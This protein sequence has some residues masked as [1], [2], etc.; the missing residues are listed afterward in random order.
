MSTG[1]KCCWILLLPLLYGVAYLDQLKPI[2]MVMG[3]G[4]TMEGRRWERYRWDSPA[5]RM[6]FAPAHWLD[7]RVRPSYWEFSRHVDAWEMTEDDRVRMS[8]P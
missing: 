8:E 7:R 1:K 4:G 5:L 6:L 2:A 3:E